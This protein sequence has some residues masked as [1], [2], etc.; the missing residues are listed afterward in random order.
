M[1]DRPI[2]RTLRGELHRRTLPR[3]GRRIDAIASVFA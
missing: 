2:K 1:S 3:R